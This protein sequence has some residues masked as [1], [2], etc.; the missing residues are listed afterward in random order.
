M[1]KSLLLDTAAWDLVLDA[2]GN[3]AVCSEPYS[4]AQDV[5]TALRT[6]LGEVYY[7]TNL[8]VPYFEKILG[9]EIPLSMLQALL[10]DQAKTVAGVVSATCT[11]I[12]LVNRQLVGQIVVTDIAGVSTNVSF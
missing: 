8:G 3:I 11:I 7:N 1:T 6:F 4:L 2:G 5:A 10:V 12:S 9:Q